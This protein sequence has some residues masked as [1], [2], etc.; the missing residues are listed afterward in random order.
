[1]TY[2]VNLA[3]YYHP[4]VVFTGFGIFVAI[5]YFIGKINGVGK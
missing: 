1:M 3:W 4:F 2:F 5:G